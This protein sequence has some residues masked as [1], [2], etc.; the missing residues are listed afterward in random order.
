M[1]K[2]FR[3]RIHLVLE[4]GDL[5]TEELA[6]PSLEGVQKEVLEV[7]P[8][9]WFCGGAE[10]SRWPARMPAMGAEAGDT[11]AIIGNG[12]RYAGVIFRSKSPASDSQASFGGHA[13]RLR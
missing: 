9:A 5:H 7:I 13:G 3:A 1:R 8:D 6:A 12:E 10:K 4:R 11:V 2:E